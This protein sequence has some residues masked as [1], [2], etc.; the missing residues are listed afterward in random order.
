MRIRALLPTLLLASACGPEAGTASARWTAPGSE[1][2]IEGEA[3]GSWCPE[4]GVVLL[5][6]SEGD[7]IVGLRWRSDSLTTGE[8]PIDLPN[9]ADTIGTKAAVAARYVQ[10]DEVRGFRGVQG[11]AR[12][13][14]ADTLG[15]SATVEARLDRLHDVDTLHLTA[16]FSRV[17]L[18]RDPTLCRA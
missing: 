16:T 14:S 2:E 18:V 11:T 12:I 1:V 13:T 17:P 4:S 6:V 10:L 7:R 9:E 8:A 5:E 3:H 15:V